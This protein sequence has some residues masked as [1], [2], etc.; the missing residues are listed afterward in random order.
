[1]LSKP[2]HRM[3]ERLFYFIHAGLLLLLLLYKC[4]TQQCSIVAELLETKMLL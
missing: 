3:M 2:F 4:A 1:M